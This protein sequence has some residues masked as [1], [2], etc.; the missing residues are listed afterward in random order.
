[1]IS[2]KIEQIP[3]HPPVKKETA[4][5]S[6]RCAKAC[7][8]IEGEVAI[9]RRV[10]P[11]LSSL[12]FAQDRQRLVGNRNPVCDESPAYIGTTAD[13]RVLRGL[14]A[15]REGP[16][17]SS[18]ERSQ[19]TDESRRG[20]YPSVLLR[21]G[22]DSSGTGRYHCIPVGASAFI[23][24]CV[25]STFFFSPSISLFHRASFLSGL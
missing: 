14:V 5:D 13:L 20:C 17:R 21:T 11:R 9:H 24:S 23:L 12:S 3:I 19:S 6:S 1:M 25:S 18:K 8:L 2:S 4:G 22:G 10:P 7:S 15:L 16:A